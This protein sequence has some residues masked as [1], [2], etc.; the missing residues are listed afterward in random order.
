MSF[1]QSE[2]F[3][4]PISLAQEAYGRHHS[5]DMWPERPQ[6]WAT[7]TNPFTRLDVISKELDHLAVTPQTVC[8]QLK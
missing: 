4:F 6:H 8:K 5:L 3:A 1:L 2:S 7:A